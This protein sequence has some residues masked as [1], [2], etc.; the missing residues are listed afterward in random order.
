MGK[1]VEQPLVSNGCYSVLK[2]EWIKKPNREAIP[3]I[4]QEAVNAE[5]KKW[6]DRYNKL[7]DSIDTDLIEEISTPEIEMIDEYLDDVYVMRRE[8]LAKDGEYSIPNLVFKKIRNSGY[9]DHLKELKHELESKELSLEECSNKE[10]VPT[11]EK[12]NKLS[13]RLS[14]KERNNYRNELSRL[15]FNQAIIQDNGLFH[16]YNV[17]ED[18]CESLKAKIRRL[19]YIEWVQSTAGKFDLS[20]AMMGGMPQRYYTV[21]GKIKD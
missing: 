2:N 7:I 5:F 6:E 8:G 20:K 3:E 19:D 16:I 4:D 14:D 17:K 12:Y 18:D 11:K 9:L 10:Q 13:E 15:S 21:Y 1:R